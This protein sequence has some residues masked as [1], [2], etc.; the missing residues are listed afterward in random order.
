ML[1]LPFLFL[2]SCYTSQIMHGIDYSN[3]PFFKASGQ[4]PVLGVIMA[5]YAF[6]TTV[7][8]WC[9][10][11]VCALLLLLRLTGYTEKRSQCKYKLV[12][13]NNSFVHCVFCP[14]IFWYALSAL[15][16]E[17]ALTLLLGALSFTFP[18]DGDILSK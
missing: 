2:V 5:N 13:S 16:A 3:V 14:G 11:K 4:S 17:H 8:S 7:P 1:S 6:V 18:P 9:S 10:E 12:D 15:F